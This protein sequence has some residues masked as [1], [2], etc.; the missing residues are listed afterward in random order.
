MEGNTGKALESPDVFSSKI[1]LGASNWSPPDSKSHHLEDTSTHT[2]S[3]LLFF[4]SLHN[5][6]FTQ[7]QRGWETFLRSTSSHVILQR[8]LVPSVNEFHALTSANVVRYNL[9]PSSPV[10][11]PLPLRCPSKQPSLLLLT[12][13][14]PAQICLRL[15]ALTIH[16]PQ[17]AFLTTA[18]SCSS[19]FLTDLCSNVISSSSLFSPLICSPVYHCLMIFGVSTTPRNYLLDFHVLSQNITSRKAAPHLSLACS[20]PRGQHRAQPPHSTP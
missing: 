7:Q 12:P 18:Q 17:R 2:A 13:F 14:P 9:L 16:L 19:I 15:L 10:D 1:C 5:P 6:F 4:P 11:N 20:I 3:L 8:P